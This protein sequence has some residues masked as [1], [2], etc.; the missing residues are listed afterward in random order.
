M[1]RRMRGGISADGRTDGRTAEHNFRFGAE[2][3]D[4]PPLLLHRICV[5]FSRE[6]RT[7]TGK[8]APAAAA[9]IKEG[10]KFHDADG[11]GKK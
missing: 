7:R 2:F 4:P 8:A 11:R 9:E 5:S 10:K 6:S 3:L 1:R